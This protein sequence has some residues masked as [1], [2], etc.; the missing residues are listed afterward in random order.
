MTVLVNR[1]LSLD[2]LG[3]IMPYPLLQVR[4]RWQDRPGA[5]LYVLNAIREVLQ[6]ELPSVQISVS[7]A[8]IRVATG[9][10][11]LGRLAVRV[12]VPEVLGWDAIKLEEMGQK[13]STLAALEAQG[14]RTLDAN[15]SHLDRPEMPIIRM[16]LNQR[17]RS[18]D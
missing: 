9:Q 11:A 14:A 18:S 1:Q 13:I 3:P 2:E 12:H 5:L 16:N 6:K 15:V 4:F 17:E 10:A 8:S 7:Y